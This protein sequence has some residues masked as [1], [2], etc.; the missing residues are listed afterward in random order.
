MKKIWF[1]SHYSMPPKY[2]MRIKTQMYAH[3]LNKMGYDTK[4]FSSSTIHNT[5][6]NLISDNTPYICRSYNDLNF[7]HIKCHNYKGNGLKR[8]RNMIEFSIKFKQIAKEFELP[9]VIVADVN[10][11]NYEPIYKFCK[12]NNIKLLLDIRDLWPLSIVEYFNL[13]EKNPIIKYLYSREKEMYKRADGI[14]FSMEGGKDY[15]IDRGW[16]DEINLSKIHYINNGVDLENFNKNKEINIINDRDLEN[17]E[18]FKVIYTGSIR[19]VNN[20]KKIVDTAKEI[21]ELGYKNIKFLIYGEGDDKE[22]LEKYCSENGLE[23][24][25][26]KGFIEKNKIPYILST[27][28]LNIFHFEQNRIKKYGASLNKM[29]EYFASGKPTISDCE[30]GYDLINKYKTGIVVDNADA[31]QLA[32]AVLKFYEMPESEYKV[33]C[34]NALNV[35]KNF[36]YS[37]L[38]RKLESLF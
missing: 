3:N 27:S 22:V 24:V 19:R 33:Y 7:V 9:N 8:I 32:K 25:I 35:A 34:N 13:S 31:K 29:F 18:Y 11:I 5:D 12:Q 21:H 20:V 17:D 26:F 4:I 6:I 14:I 15:I 23:N 1:V 36:D 16:H 28:N 2:E 10:C 38:T 30:F 37:V